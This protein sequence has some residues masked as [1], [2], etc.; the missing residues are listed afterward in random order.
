VGFPADAAP[1]DQQSSVPTGE[2]AVLGS[3]SASTGG[4][5]DGLS[6]KEATLTIGF[7]YRPLSQI[8]NDRIPQSAPVIPV[9]ATKTVADFVVNPYLNGVRTALHAKL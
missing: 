9:L 5:W 2:K 6:G 1:L 3:V 4:L 8:R 7:G